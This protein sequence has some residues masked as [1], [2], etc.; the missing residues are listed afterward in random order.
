[1]SRSPKRNGVILNDIVTD[2]NWPLRDDVPASSHPPRLT[3]SSNS[4]SDSVNSSSSMPSTPTTDSFLLP[5]FHF[6]T[7]DADVDVAEFHRIAAQLLSGETSKH[8]S[9]VA[10]EIAKPAQVRHLHC[11]LGRDPSGRYC[12]SC[13]KSFAASLQLR[14]HVR[15]CAGI[16]NFPC[17][18]CDKIFPTQEKLD[19]HNAARHNNHEEECPECGDL[20][21]L[22]DL[23]KHLSSGFGGCDGMIQASLGP[24]PEIDPAWQCPSNKSPSQ[25][26]WIYDGD[27]SWNQSR[28]TARDSKMD[29]EAEEAPAERTL[30]FITHILRRPLS[31]PD[32]QKCDLCGDLFD[33][34]DDLAQH[35]G[36][37]SLDFAEKRHRCD[38]CLIYFANEKDLDRHLQSANLNHHCGFTFR[39]NSGLCRGHHPPTYFKSSLVHDHTLMQKHL[40]A[41]ELSQLRMHRVTVAR[42]LAERLNRNS[43]RHMS[44]QD[45]RRAYSSL[46]PHVSIASRDSTSASQP[47]PPP[48]TSRWSQ[49]SDLDAHF[50][51]IISQTFPEEDSQTL[52]KIL[53][54]NEALDIRPDSAVMME[55][56]PNSKAF[57]A[58]RKSFVE[59]A[60]KRKSLVE[61]VRASASAS[62]SGHRRNHSSPISF[63]KSASRFESVRPR[64][65]PGAGASS[66]VVKLV[67]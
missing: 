1:M 21:Q 12:C 8:D 62:A 36:E 3:L 57:V 30:S 52:A 37:H 34:D 50:S 54:A 26:F 28:T 9:V 60:A 17:I 65:L 55:P 59:L 49:E 38:E 64:S 35:I 19:R 18:T 47:P 13:G 32:K 10:E 63:L 44:V 2:T 24:V 15:H 7:T 22:K 51:R 58:P 29:E 40:W 11:D 42:L 48:T 41:W 25:H 66:M 39:H 43:S 46:L 23:P 14:E 31:E 56:A 45:C 67:A 5:G 33:T 4:S 27:L 53:E 61:S 20:Y 16:T 6:S